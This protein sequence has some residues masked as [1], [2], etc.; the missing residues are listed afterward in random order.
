VGQVA[1]MVKTEMSTELGLENQKERFPLQGL[2]V[3]GI[4]SE[5]LTST[6]KGLGM[7][8]SRSG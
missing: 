2:G 8:S 1:G 3:E 5:Y 6:M 4:H 7:D